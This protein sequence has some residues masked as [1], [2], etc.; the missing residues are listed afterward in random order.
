[1]VKARRFVSFAIAIIIMFSLLQN[2]VVYA[3]TTHHD[4]TMEELQEAAQGI[5]DLRNREQRYYLRQA[6]D[7]TADW[8]I[9]ALGSLGQ[10]A[11]YEDYLA[12]LKDRVYKRYQEKGKLDPVKSTE[13]QRISLA[14]LAC[15][16]DPSNLCENASGESINLI[17]DGIYDRGKIVPLDAQGINGYIWALITLDAGGY[18]VPS[19][20]AD[21][22]ES[23]IKGILSYELESGGFA[24]GK[25][26]T[27][28]DC[29]LT[30]MAL[31][32]LAPYEQDAKYP[33]VK[34]VVERALTLLSKRQTKDG[35]FISYG[36]QNVEST[37]QVMMALCAL[38]IDPMKDFR[39]IKGHHTIL[40][41]IMKYRQADGGFVHSYT[42][43]ED[44]PTADPKESNSMAGEQ[45]LLAISALMRY[46]RGDS[47]V[48]AFG[49][50][51]RIDVFHGA[52]MVS[53][54]IHISQ[55]EVE[56]FQEIPQE[57][58]MEYEIPVICLLDKLDKADNGGDYEY[59]R[60]ELQEKKKQLDAIQEQIEKI[61]IEVM[62]KLYPYEEISSKDAK[63]V[64]AIVRQIQAL[65][66]YDQ[67]QVA[68]YED[69]MRT[70]HR[71]Q[72]L[73][74]TYMISLTLILFILVLVFILGIRLKKRKRERYEEEHWFEME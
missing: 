14:V 40:D 41:G 30:A 31:Q 35:D 73:Q 37:A 26:E 7:S 23:I 17:A 42:Y 50:G 36:S 11:P 9:I 39:F 69:V 61:N 59:L 20:A 54:H 48:Y 2:F 52:E 62:H 49:T 34:G 1:M 70:S 27:E 55:E 6:A 18:E 72:T 10:E 46:Y 5:I 4:Y 51:K 68:G 60:P 71:I 8:Y 28:A 56:E 63:E 44:N 45:T 13:W 38:G 64:A 21:T 67:K 16:A 53:T 65:S 22:R 24:L 25:K 19:G 47:G 29:D 15:G 58:T 74:R 12:V 32:A 3:E 66:E 57:I 33:E 43:S